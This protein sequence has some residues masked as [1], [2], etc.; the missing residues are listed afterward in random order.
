MKSEG[1]GKSWFTPMVMVS[2]ALLSA[3]GLSAGGAHGSPAG[4][5]QGQV[6]EAPA[7]RALPTPPETA[8]ALRHRLEE[9]R[10]RIGLEFVPVPGG[11]FEMQ[12]T[13]GGRDKHL[14]RVAGFLLG[15]HEVTVRQFRAFVEATGYRTGAETDRGCRQLQAAGYWQAGGTATWR[16]PGFPQGDDHPVVCVSWFDAEAFC[17]W[18][19]VRLLT[20]A[21]WEYAAGHGA[22]RVDYAW[23][24]GKPEGKKSGNLAG[25]EVGGA[26]GWGGQGIFS[27]HDDGYR[28]TAPVGSYAPSALGLFD[29]TGN[30]LEWT[31]TSWGAMGGG[32]GGVPFGGL[33]YALRGGSWQSVPENARNSSATS[34]RS[35]NKSDFVGFRVARDAP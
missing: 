32:S 34:Y 30:V 1:K 23:G 11:E 15:R 10:R 14:V 2:T 4:G 25:R 31:S 24:D 27:G 7:A 5:D 28:Y 6:K 12:T 19:G 20:E 29:T 21:E 18:A 9:L 22:P 13:G 3:A 8:E 35:R 16:D 33:S 17:A 26:F